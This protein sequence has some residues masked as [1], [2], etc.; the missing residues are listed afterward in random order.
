MFLSHFLDAMFRL[1]ADQTEHSVEEYQRRLHIKSGDLQVA[2]ERIVRL[3]ERISKL[4][5]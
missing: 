1:I 3:E 2:E 5:C 4:E